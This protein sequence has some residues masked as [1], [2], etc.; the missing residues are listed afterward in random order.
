MEKYTISYMRRLNTVKM[1][2]LSELIYAHVAT[3]ETQSSG[4]LQKEKIKTKKPS[5][6]LHLKLNLT[7]YKN[8]SKWV[9]G[10]KVRA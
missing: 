2:I 8:E 7:P 4:I 6:L 1:L 10:L 5:R 3:S 9:K